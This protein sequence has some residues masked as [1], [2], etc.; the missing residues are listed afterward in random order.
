VD[1]LCT[2]PA[3]NC[4]YCGSSNT[5]RYGFKGKMQYYKCNN[6]KR[7]FAGRITFERM[8]FPD[9]TISE[10]LALFYDGLSLGDICKHIIATHGIFVHPSSVWRWVI[11]YSKEAIGILGNIKI[12]SRRWVIDEQVKL[13]AGE[14]IWIWDIIDCD[15][16]FLLTTYTSLQKNIYS[17]TEA[18]TQAQSHSMQAPEQI[19]SNKIK[20][21]TSVLEQ[22][23]GADGKNI[24]IKTHSSDINVVE[25]FHGAT[26]ER[27]E[28]I[29]KLKK[30]ES[31]KLILTSYIVN[32]NFLRPHPEL[33][34]FTPA[35]NAGLIMPFKIWNDFINYLAKTER[36]TRTQEKL[37]I[38]T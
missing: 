15:T 23:F 11:R 12:N 8:R 32:Y 26:K 24:L 20:V 31:I 17:L 37:A 27:K 25:R 9:I 19:T 35:R 36:N 21:K 30:F 1:L 16:D 6:C 13:K 3:M 2:I 18:L 34:L 14:K 33:D 10:A 4:K 29:R 7:K 38:L 28:I 22:I 5:I